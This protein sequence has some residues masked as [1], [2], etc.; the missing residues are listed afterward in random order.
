MRLLWEVCAQKSN[1]RGQSG[2]WEG[3]HLGFCQ[4]WC[5]EDVGH[6]TYLRIWWQW[7]SRCLE[8]AWHGLHPR[9]LVK[10]CCFEKW[11]TRGP[12]RWFASAEPALLVV[13]K[14][15]L[16]PPPTPPPHYRLW[17]WLAV[18]PRGETGTKKSWK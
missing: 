10:F 17:R 9:Q 13:G 18:N 4:R 3:N 6:A 16:C 5:P 12:C 8:L 1:S 2:T 7:V 14:T 15:D 11:V